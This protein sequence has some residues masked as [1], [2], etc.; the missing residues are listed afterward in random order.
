MPERLRKLVYLSHATIEDDVHTLT[1]TIEEI[2]ATSRRN[3][4]RAEITGALMFNHGYFAQVLEGT[5]RALEATFERI[6]MD[7]RHNRVAILA[8]DEVSHR[9]FESWSMGW[10]GDVETESANAFATLSEKAD[11]QTREIAGERIYALLHRR[12]REGGM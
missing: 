1:P 10:V 4:A 8:Y 6:Q 11:Q 9:V 3:N 5:Q 7:E 12:L 2:L